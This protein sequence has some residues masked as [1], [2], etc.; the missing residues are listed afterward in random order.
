MEHGNTVHS[1]HKAVHSKQ[2]PEAIMIGGSSK[3]VSQE[4][5]DCVRKRQEMEDVDN[6]HFCFGWSPY[7]LEYAE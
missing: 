4:K 7:D 5:I 1:E 2:K 6:E 3:E